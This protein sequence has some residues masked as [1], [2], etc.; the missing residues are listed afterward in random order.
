MLCKKSLHEL[1]GPADYVGSDCRKCF[2]DRQARYDARR[3]TAMAYLR[4]L[5][6]RAKNWSQ[7]EN[8]TIAV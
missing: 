7:D 8:H 3:R 6:S 2:Y 4:E 1:R 5:E